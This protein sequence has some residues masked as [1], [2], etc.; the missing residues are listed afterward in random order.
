MG[1]RVGEAEASQKTPSKNQHGRPR[2][3][4]IMRPERPKE[5]YF[6]SNGCHGDF[7]SIFAPSSLTTSNSAPLIRN[8]A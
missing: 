2:T 3:L 8:L 6:N 1:W 4:H 5:A 7:N